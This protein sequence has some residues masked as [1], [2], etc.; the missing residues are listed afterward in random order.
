MS[1]QAEEARSVVGRLSDDARG[2]LLLLA[3]G[4]C[5]A[6]LSAATKELATDLPAL[7][8]GAVRNVVALACFAPMIWRRGFALVRTER[9]WSHFFRSVFGYVSFLAFIYV[10][11]ILTLADVIALSFTTPLWS[12]LLSALFM[13]EPIPARRWIAVAIGFGGVLL[14]A[15]PTSAIGWATAIALAS[16]VLASLA[17]MKVKQLSRTEPPDRIAFY[18]MF[19]GML[20]GTPLAAPVWQMPTGHAWLLLLGIGA[21]SFLSQ[22]CLTRGYALGQFSKM[23]PMDYCRLPF[24]ILTGFVFFG[25]LPDAL[26]VLGMAIVVA[27]TLYIVMARQAP[28]AR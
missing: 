18:F 1:G 21:L 3:S 12:L 26:S 11:P 19:N 9:Y 7:V 4:L 17:M 16:A 2:A 13:G 25:E 24:G 8:I 15:K 14:I 5:F 28:R 27:S 10:L 23:A 6:V 20:I 22:R